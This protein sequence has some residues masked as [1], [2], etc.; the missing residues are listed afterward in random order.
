MH[1]AHVCHPDLHHAAAC[2]HTATH[3][4][5]MLSCEY[6]GWW[7]KAAVACVYNHGENAVAPPNPL[8]Q[9]ETCT[10]MCAYIHRGTRRFLFSGAKAA[11]QEQWEA[12]LAFQ[13]CSS[14]PLPFLPLLSP[15]CILQV[16]M[17]TKWTNYTL[18]FWL[19]Q[20]GS[21]A[22]RELLPSNRKID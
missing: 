12:C 8:G 17:R 4:W 18:W 13:S 6:F 14:L 16:I 9:M 15:S 7:S 10:C 19:K 22:R 20:Q 5:R 2:A 3:V 11:G 1:L 21:Q